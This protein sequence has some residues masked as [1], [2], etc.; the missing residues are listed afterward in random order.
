M[1]IIAERGRFRITA[2]DVTQ[3]AVVDLSVVQGIIGHVKQ[4]R[5]DQ[6]LLLLSMIVATMEAAAACRPAPTDEDY[7][8]WA[9]LRS[10]VF[11]AAERIAPGSG[12]PNC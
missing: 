9:E 7:A 3:S 1:T 6:A 8:T 2:I 4:G 10:A 12:N 11:D 5:N